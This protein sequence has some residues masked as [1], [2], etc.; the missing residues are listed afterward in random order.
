MKNFKR[1]ATDNSG[2]PTETPETPQT[3]EGDKAVVHGQVSV[4]DM[5][6][7]DNANGGEVPAEEAPADATGADEAQPE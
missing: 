7:T 1:N 3:P 4:I 2:A 5:S 6:E